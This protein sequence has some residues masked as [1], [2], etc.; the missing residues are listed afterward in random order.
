MRAVILLLA[1]AGCVEP[2]ETGCPTMISEAGRR[3]QVACEQAYY[4]EKARQ[5]GGEITRCFNSGSETT[6]ITE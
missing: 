6:C 2:N 4:E 1:L 3:M 5:S